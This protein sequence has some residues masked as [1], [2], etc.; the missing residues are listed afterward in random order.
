MKQ[1]T[2]ASEFIVISHRTKNIN[3]A[4]KFCKQTKYNLFR[5]YS[6]EIINKFNKLPEDERLLNECCKNQG[7]NN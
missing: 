2:R 6:I 5:C 3:K 1:R 7:A 4:C